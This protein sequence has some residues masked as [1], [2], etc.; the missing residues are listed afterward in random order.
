MIYSL[1]QVIRETS[2]DINH[3]CQPE[4]DRQAKGFAIGHG[5]KDKNSKISVFICVIRGQNS[6]ILIILSILSTFLF[7]TSY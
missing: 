5:R 7:R 3:I 2:T 6:F 4:Q 1:I